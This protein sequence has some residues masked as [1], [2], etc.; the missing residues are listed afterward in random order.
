MTADF[1]FSAAQSSGMLQRLRASAEWRFLGVFAQAGRGLTAAWWLLVAVRGLLPAIFAVAMGALG[2]AGSGHHSLT[3]P[4]ATVGLAF[5]AMNALGPVHGAAG[6]LLGAKSGAW[7]HDRLMA[8]T[9]EPP[10]I[11]HLERPELADEL[12]R[13][14]E[15]DNGILAPPLTA[16]L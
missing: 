1:N 9:V 3:A 5:V 11:A 4:L 7:L 16:A 13:A 6:S 2:G 8:A 10:G 15:F 14:R 12:S